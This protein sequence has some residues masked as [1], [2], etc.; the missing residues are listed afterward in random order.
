[1]ALTDVE[2]CSRALVKIGAHPIGSFDEASIE[3]DVARELYSY[4]L[5]GLLAVHPWSFSLV[6]SELERDTAVSGGEFAHAYDLPA[7]LLRVLSARSR[8]GHRGIAYRLIGKHLLS[9]APA[10]SLIYQRSVPEAEFPPFFAHLLIGK[11]A[12][13]F[14]IPITEDTERADALHGLAQ[15][16]IE[17]SILADR[18][19]ATPRAVED[20][21]LVDVRYR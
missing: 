11:L 7:G 16:E 3:A 10:V 21:T 8:S 18:R 1:M 20:F 6:Q 2:L 17:R 15:R 12:A 14:V 4:T 13:D 19:Q 9:D 5:D